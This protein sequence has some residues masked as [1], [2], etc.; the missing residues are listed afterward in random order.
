MQLMA[1]L[2]H[3]VIDESDRRETKL[4]IL[5]ELLRNHA[6]GIAR[7]RDDHPAN[8]MIGCRLVATTGQGSRARA[9]G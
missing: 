8:V 9:T 2:R 7:T 5:E 1:V 4:R 3:V 6:T